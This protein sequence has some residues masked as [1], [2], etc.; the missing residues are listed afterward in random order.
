MHAAGKCR[1]IWECVDQK[2]RELPNGVPLC[3][4]SPV[5]TPNIIIDATLSSKPARLPQAC[6]SSIKE[7]LVEVGMRL[8]NHI[9]SGLRTGKGQPVIRSIVSHLLRIC[10]ACCQRIHNAPCAKWTYSVVVVL[11]NNVM[12]QIAVP[13]SFVS[14]GV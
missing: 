9:T 11:S 3:K 8:E 13:A 7:P 4:A 6:P 2:R 1:F 12:G 10:P 5:D 14:C